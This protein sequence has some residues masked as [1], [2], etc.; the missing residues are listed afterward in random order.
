METYYPVRL[1][2]KPKL[3]AD[4]RYEIKYYDYISR[5]KSLFRNL[6]YTVIASEV[7]VLRSRRKQDYTTGLLCFSR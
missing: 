4:S 5:S 7:R 1:H 3:F 6:R 2:V